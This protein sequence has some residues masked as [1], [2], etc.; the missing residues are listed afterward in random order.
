MAGS[1]VAR[2]RQQ[3]QAEYE[4]AKQGL[5]GLSSGTARH[6]FIAARYER[7]GAFHEQL[8]EMIGPDEAVAIIAHTIWLPIDS[9][10]A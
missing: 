6:T 7:I 2:L 9:G 1:E 10:T 4:A 3:I 5:S 8:I